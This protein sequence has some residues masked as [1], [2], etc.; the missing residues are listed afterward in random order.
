MNDPRVISVD[1]FVRI[2]LI[3]VLAGDYYTLSDNLRGKTITARSDGERD[4]VVGLNARYTLGLETVDSRQAQP[5]LFHDIP[6]T[7]IT[8]K[9]IDASID[10]LESAIFKRMQAKR[11]LRTL[12]RSRALARVEKNSRKTYADQ[13]ERAAIATA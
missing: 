6:I 8:A 3:G 11:V 2:V 13:H 10:S 7:L 9:N 1:Q 5:A 12:P 4:T